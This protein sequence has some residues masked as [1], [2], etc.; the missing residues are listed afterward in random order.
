MHIRCGSFPLV[1]QLLFFL[2]LLFLV[3]QARFGEL[4]WELGFLLT[5]DQLLLDEALVHLVD[6]RLALIRLLLKGDFNI[7]GIVSEQ[8]LNRM[9]HKFKFGIKR[10]VDLT[11]FSTAQMWASF[12]A[13]L[14]NYFAETW[15]VPFWVLLKELLKEDCVLNRLL[16]KPLPPS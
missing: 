2:C 1:S 14:W 10:S 12:I 15:L 9:R 5:E 3:G 8:F 4:R 16:E 11:K 6:V 13:S 7:L